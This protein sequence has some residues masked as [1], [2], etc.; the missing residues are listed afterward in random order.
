M[1]KIASFF[2]YQLQFWLLLLNVT[3]V[4]QIAGKHCCPKPTDFDSNQFKT[5]IDASENASSKFSNTSA[6]ASTLQVQA[7]RSGQN[8]DTSN[9]LN[10]LNQTSDFDMQT[11]LDHLN[12]LNNPNNLIYT[13]QY[14]VELKGGPKLAKELSEKH[15]FIYLG[16]VR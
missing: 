7:A 3:C 4:T 8:L 13:D 11:N 2:I 6:N 9:Q 1:C 12:E 16:Q 14:V 10:S 15:G 5:Q